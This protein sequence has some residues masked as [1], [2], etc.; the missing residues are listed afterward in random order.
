MLSF[1]FFVLVFWLLVWY[2]LIVWR[3]GRLCIGGAG[4]YADVGDWEL[5]FACKVVLSWAEVGVVF[6]CFTEIDEFMSLSQVKEGEKKENEK[7]K[8]NPNSTL[9]LGATTKSI[10]NSN[11]SSI[12]QKQKQKHTLSAPSSF[13]YPYPSLRKDTPQHWWRIYGKLNH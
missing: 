3:G 13:R 11:T 10:Q 2:M 12:P 7:R 5:V 8:S 6:T 1:P 9:N 4:G